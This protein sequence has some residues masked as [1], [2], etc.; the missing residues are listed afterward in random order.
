M[1]LSFGT[2]SMNLA[3]NFTR[4]GI[5]F[6]LFVNGALATWT[7]YNHKATDILAWVENGMLFVSVDGMTFKV[8]AKRI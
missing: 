8:E 1:M 4:F 6:G 7:L 3:V 5:G 2:E